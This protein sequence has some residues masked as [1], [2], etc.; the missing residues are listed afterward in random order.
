MSFSF[1]SVG[2]SKEKYLFEDGL[3]VWE[4]WNVLCVTRGCV[5]VCARERESSLRGQANKEEP[6]ESQTWPGG[7]G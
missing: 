2:Y 7:V 1:G 4:E 6:F 3:S 5:C